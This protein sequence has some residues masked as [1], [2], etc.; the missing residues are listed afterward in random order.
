[1]ESEYIY[2]INNFIFYSQTLY[3][4]KKH[5]IGIRYDFS[6][7]DYDK[8]LS[9]VYGINTTEHIIFKTEYSI[10]PEKKK[11]IFKRYFS[12]LNFII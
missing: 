10:S 7:I 5:N 4:I 9:F 6:K 1:M 8:L 12:L 11:N 2:H 3:K